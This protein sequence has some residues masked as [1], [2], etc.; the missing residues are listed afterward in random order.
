MFGIL[1]SYKNQQTFS[2]RA[3]F[4]VSVSLCDSR[5]CFDVVLVAIAMFLTYV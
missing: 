4:N 2:K 3:R 5:A 1:L